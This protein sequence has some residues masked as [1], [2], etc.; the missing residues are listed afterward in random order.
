M[1]GLRSRRQ[2]D[3]RSTAQVLHHYHRMHVRLPTYSRGVAE[4]GRDEPDRGDDVFL[5]LIL[6]LSLPQIRQHRRGPQCSAPGPEILRRIW[7]LRD[8]LDVVVDVV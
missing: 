8:P 7:K 4:L 2:R 6:A 5:A 3:G 1:S